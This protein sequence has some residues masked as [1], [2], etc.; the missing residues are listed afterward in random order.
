MRVAIYILLSFLC[1][2]SNVTAQ[3][4]LTGH[5]NERLLQGRVKQ[6]EEFMARFNGE[7]DWQGNAVD[8][9]AD[10]LLRARY[11]RTLFD[12]ER[13]PLKD[14]HLSREAE[15]FISLVMRHD[16]RLSYADTTWEASVGCVARYRDLT[17]PL[18]LR[19]RTHRVGEHQYRWRVHDVEGTLPDTLRTELSN[20]MLSP[21]EHETGFTAL[22]S[23]TTSSGMRM[24]SVGRVSYHFHGIPGYTFTIERQERKNSYNTGW[25]ITT[26]EKVKK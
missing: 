20:L 26:L 11:L 10:T 3:V 17:M 1:M 25:L 7:E 18:T 15:Q 6:V 23:V 22:L 4:L 13:Y 2:V 14:K 19:L 9:T 24:K 8:Y 5:I 16:C 12:H 21:V